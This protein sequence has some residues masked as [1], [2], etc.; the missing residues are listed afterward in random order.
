[1]RKNLGI[2]LILTLLSMI[3]SVD[4]QSTIDCDC[5]NEKNKEIENN[6]GY[7]NCFCREISNNPSLIDKGN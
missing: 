5:N 2:I 1:M 3:S 4:S 7:C 6:N